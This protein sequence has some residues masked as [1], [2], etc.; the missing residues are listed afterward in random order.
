MCLFHWHKLKGLR[1]TP[2][3]RACPFLSAPK[4]SSL[5]TAIHTGLLCGPLPFSP[6]KS[7]AHK[8]E[9]IST[10]CGPGRQTYQ[11][12]TFLL[13]CLP[14]SGL[15]APKSNVPWSQSFSLQVGP[16]P[17]PKSPAEDFSW[18][19]TCGF[20]HSWISNPVLGVGT[21]FITATD[22]PTHPLPG[23]ASLKTLW[24][25]WGNG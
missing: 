5:L 7:L 2:K 18:P 6:P 12:I 22:P 17:V 19:P 1:G 3:L 14:A 23:P 16:L 11:L 13:T 15:Q 20:L 10:G 25:Q 24:K 21:R 8:S 4:G 9:H